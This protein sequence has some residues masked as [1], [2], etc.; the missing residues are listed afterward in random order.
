M[1]ETINEDLALHLWSDEPADADLLSFAE[2]AD[3]AVDALLDDE[4][5]PVALGISGSWGSGKTTVLNLINQGI[6]ARAIDEGKKVVVVRADPWRF[7][8][9]VGPK[10]SLIS[11][12]LAA[13]SQEFADTDGVGKAAV[14]ALKKLAKRVNW[15]KAIKM[16]AKTALTFQIP[17]LDDILGLV[18]EDPNTLDSERG[19]AAF[20]E[21]FAS[22]LKEP[23]L[24][25]IRGVVVLVDDLDRCLPETVVETL[26]AI[27]LFLSVAGMSFVIAADEQRVAEAIQ[28]KLQSPLGS[29]EGESV[30]D[31]YLHKIVQTTI[32][33]PA[34]SAFD[35]RAYLFLLMADGAAIDDYAYAALVRDVTVLRRGS[36]NL[37]DLSLPTSDD[38][39]LFMATAS[40]LTP[41]LYE[42]F[43]GNPRRIKRFLN[44]VAVRQ[45]V[46]RRRGIALHTDAIAK[47]MVLERLLPKDF[48]LLLDW[49]ADG[50]LATRMEALQRVADGSDEDREAG[51][52]PESQEAGGSETFSGGMVRWAKLSPRLEPGEVPSYLTLAA[53][54]KGRVLLDERLSE[55]LRDIAAALTATS[56]VEREAITDSDLT[57]LP[58]GDVA[59]LL[60][61]LG[62]RLRNDPTVQL[63][64][65]NSIIR[66]AKLHPSELP[67]AKV[68]LMRLPS[69]E[70]GVSTTLVMRGI[71]AEYREVLDAWGANPSEETARAIARVRRG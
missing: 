41:I 63:Q 51:D 4:L 5:D 2:I 40:R 44:D 36:G 39:P 37:D 48:D 54:F 53:A 43:R 20:R 49:L 18:S 62:R 70:V 67:D 66:L 7:D 28:Q 1:T 60:E 33:V 17:S 61:F 69:P 3:T 68:A 71:A 19:M 65:V 42:K 26:E 55:R 11:E 25:H 9:T 31:L 35:T 27:R 64:T 47:L 38:L 57:G 24:D 32:P 23:A 14:D 30:A 13:L 16:T 34:L 59:E 50:E 52:E 6:E 21:E 58:S 45:S 46:A 10:E 22:L 12:V 8:P 56:Q 29:D 15:S